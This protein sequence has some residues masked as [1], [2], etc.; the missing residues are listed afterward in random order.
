MDIFLFLKAKMGNIQSG[1]YY[2]TPNKKHRPCTYDEF[3]LRKKKIRARKDLALQKEHHDLIEKSTDL[4][5]KSQKQRLAQEQ[6]LDFIPYDFITE[7]IEKYGY[8]CTNIEADRYRYEITFRKL[9]D[10][11]WN[12]ILNDVL[13]D[14][15]L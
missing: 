7:Q 12:E 15:D 2:G 13:N 8:R 10:G 9:S 14:H 11:K 1:I 5:Y 3:E 6:R 4:L